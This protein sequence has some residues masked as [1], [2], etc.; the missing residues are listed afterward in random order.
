MGFEGRVGNKRCYSPLLIFSS[1]RLL[2]SSSSPLLVFSSL[3]RLCSSCFLF[4]VFSF[5]VF[6][7]LRFR[8][9]L[10]SFLSVFSSSR[11]FVFSAYKLTNHL[12]IH[13]KSDI[14]VINASYHVSIILEA[15]EAANYTYAIG[16]P[17]IFII[18]A[19][20]TRG[21]RRQRQPKGY[22]FH[23]IQHTNTLLHHH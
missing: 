15:I 5:F 2:P 4:F 13:S 19:K 8:F 17:Q 3:R 12:R 22:V 1:P 23:K 10:F 9:F 18:R 21:T 11:L 14:I 16:R 6:S 20:R 7:Y